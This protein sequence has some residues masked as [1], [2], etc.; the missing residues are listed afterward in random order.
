MSY[1]GGFS[2]GPSGDPDGDG[3]TNLQEYQ[4]G[5]DPNDADTD[6]D[7]VSDGDE[8]ANGTDPL[9]NL[10]AILSIILE[11]LLSD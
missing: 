11:L 2:Q 5:T 3:L 10:P 1:F 7:G 4:V 8:V 6:N 9:L